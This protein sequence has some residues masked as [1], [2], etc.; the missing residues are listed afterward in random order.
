MYYNKK[1]NHRNPLKLCQ[2]VRWTKEN[3]YA[4]FEQNPMVDKRDIQVNNLGFLQP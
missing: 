3:K 1:T 2:K 4:K